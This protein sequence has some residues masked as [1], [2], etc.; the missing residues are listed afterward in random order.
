MNRFKRE[1][2]QGSGVRGQGSE[3]K[4]PPSSPQA[5]SLKPQARRLRRRSRIANYWGHTDRKGSVL[6]VVLGLLLLLMLVG[7]TFFTFASQEHVAAE[8]YCDSMKSNYEGIDTDR[9]M[10]FALR[11]LIIGPDESEKQSVLYP[12][13]HS[14]VPNAIGTLSA[15]KGVP[16]INDRRPFNGTGINLISGPNGEVDVDQDFDGVADGGQFPKLLEINHSQLANNQ[17]YT[18]ADFLNPASGGIP[19]PS[20]DAGYTYPDINNVFLAYIDADAK[21]NLVITP[22]FHRPLVLRKPNGTPYSDWYAIANTATRVLRPHPDHMI[23]GT[24]YKRFLSGTA[25]SYGAQT[26]Q[27]FFKRDGSNK[28]ICDANGNNVYGEQGAWDNTGGPDYDVDNDGDSLLEGVLLDLGFPM[29]TLPDGRKYVVLYSMTVVDADGLINLNQAGNLA[30]H[31]PYNTDL[32]QLIKGG[33]LGLPISRSN[34]GQSPAEINPWWALYADPNSVNNSTAD[35][36]QYRTFLNSNTYPSNRLEMGNTDLLFLMWGRP[37]YDGSTIKDVLEGRWGEGGTLLAA[38]NGNSQAYPRP[39]KP[40]TDDDAD[41]Y[42]GTINEDDFILGAGPNSGTSLRIP[43][44]RYP[45]DFDGSGTSLANGANGLI[46]DV[47]RPAGWPLAWRRYTSYQNAGTYPSAPFG[48]QTMPPA[49]LNSTGLL[50]FTLDMVSLPSYRDGDEMI[51]DRRYRVKFGGYDQLYGPQEIAGLH[52]SPKDYKKALGSSR[53][54]QVMPFNFEQSA[55]AAAIRKLFTTESWDRRE[56]GFRGTAARPWEFNANFSGNWSDVNGDSIPNFPELGAGFPPVAPAAAGLSNHDARQPF[57][58][59]LQAAIA[60]EVGDTSLVNWPQW[61]LNINRFLTVLDPTALVHQFGGNTGNPL[62]LPNNPLQYRQLTPHPVDPGA[63]LI[64]GSPGALQPAPTSFNPSQSAAHQEYW[65]RRD[66]QQ[67][68]RDIYVMLYM[69]GGGLVREDLNSNGTLDPNEIDYNQD[70]VADDF[71]DYSKSQN[72]RPA[73]LPPNASGRP[74]YDEWQ[75]QEMAQFAV[76]YVDALDRDDVITM[77]EYDMNLADGWNLDDNPYTSTNTTDP[78]AGSNDR[79][80][81]FGVEA[82]QLTINEALV[83]NSMKVPDKTDPTKFI[84]HPATQFD[85]R[86]NTA[87]TNVGQDRYFTYIELQNVSPYDVRVGTAGGAGNPGDDAWEIAVEDPQNPVFNNRRLK[88]RDAGSFVPAGGIYTIGSR[89]YFQGPTDDNGANAPYP[90]YFK[91][92]PN[93]S[94]TNPNT[95]NLQQIVPPPGNSLSLDLVDNSG[96]GRYDL[97]DA[98]NNFGARGSFVVGNPDM[99]GNGVFPYDI[100]FVLRRRLHLTRSQLAPADDGDNPWI[101]VDR[102][103]VQLIRAD[104]NYANDDALPHTTAMGIV[105]PEIYSFRL[106][107][108]STAALLGDPAANDIQPKLGRLRSVERIQ[109]LS[110]FDWNLHSPPAGGAWSA[111]TIGLTNEQSGIAL[112]PGSNQVVSQPQFDRDFTSVVDLLSIPLYGPSEVVDKLAYRRRLMSEVLL[113]NSTNP[114][115]FEARTAQAKFLRP[116]FPNTVTNSGSTVIPMVISPPDAATDKTKTNVFTISPIPDPFFG[117]SPTTTVSAFDGAAPSG[118]D[119]YDQ[120]RLDNHWHRVLELLEVPG[121]ANMQI[122]N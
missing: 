109:P 14:L 17:N 60:M 88:L 21:N 5:S 69:F 90:S 77:F 12:G 29:Q 73:T 61:R 32:V 122:E 75:L 36:A 16:K 50:D 78:A 52:L 100:H 23:V 91:V 96:D 81:V 15:S 106:I 45:T 112:P 121:R 110:R 40:G 105:K 103:Q 47:Y 68:A 35:L 65:A 41:Q 108:P 59:E 95:I 10:D 101:E 48:A 93:W 30:A 79:G 3:R 2:I 43:P 80:V 54:R 8:Y 18:R 56:H 34:L 33:A 89:T 19:F 111:T 114:Q 83:V 87:G 31:D 53:L 98:N 70:L 4:R 63:S 118:L 44:L 11:Q 64:P 58:P 86:R 24:T 94:P 37:K 42:E 62:Y 13:T 6:L 20:I 74:L 102:F 113:P 92:D 38:L 104:T 72:K 57:R 51:T 82:Q 116:D 1:R 66:R 49:S 67:M 25:V 28:I 119:Q 46:P 26:I 9:L 76:N 115:S 120:W 117:Y 99:L 107:D 97:R 7:F 22:S 84:D 39:G 71:V 55:E 27:P 85:E